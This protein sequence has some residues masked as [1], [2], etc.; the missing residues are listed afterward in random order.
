MGSIVVGSSSWL[1]SEQ[2][3]GRA[4]CG[5]GTRLEI[6]GD[7]NLLFSVMIPNTNE[8]SGGLDMSLFV[9][10]ALQ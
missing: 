10:G 6:R 8:P 2:K 9:Y 5:G 1:N 7:S 3:S 4:C